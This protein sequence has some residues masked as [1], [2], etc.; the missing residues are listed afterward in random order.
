MLD[1]SV[2]RMTARS[3]ALRVPRIAWPDEAA[4]ALRLGATSVLAILLAMWLE[5]DTPA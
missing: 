3:A 4:T 2:A 1:A 5:L